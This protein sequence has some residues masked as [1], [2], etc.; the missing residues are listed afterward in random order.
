MKEHINYYQL[1]HKRLNEER[2]A[3]TYINNQIISGIIL[4]IGEHDFNEWYASQIESC[5]R[6]SKLSL[7]ELFSESSK[8]IHDSLKNELCFSERTPCIH[9]DENGVHETPSNEILEQ[10]LY[11]A[12]ITD[13]LFWIVHQ[14]IFEYHFIS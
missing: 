14:T 3:S 5:Q 2:D 7:N 9:Y 11:H 1:F 10:M 8:L 6:F 12:L 4:L 13:S